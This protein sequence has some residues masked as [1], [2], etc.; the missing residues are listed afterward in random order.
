MEDFQINK[1]IDLCKL[2]NTDAFKYIVAEYQQLVYTLALKMMCNEAEAED[3]T[4]ETFIKAWQNIIR[5]N[6]QY[7]FSTWIYKIAANICYDK[8]RSKPAVENVA[9]SEYDA[10]YE[11]NQEELLDN[12]ELKKLIIKFT[13]GLSPKQK[14]IFMLSE[15]EELEIEEI[16]QITGM[17]ASKIKS[18]L[19]LARKQIKSKLSQ[20]E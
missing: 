7:K 20:Y 11:V 19:Y 15:I 16:I 14:L 2:G 12:K 17:T 3:I 6:R 18:N 4:Q 10:V 5:Y 1:Y 9:L 8:L 13:S